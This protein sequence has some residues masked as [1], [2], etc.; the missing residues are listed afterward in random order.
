VMLGCDDGVGV[1]LKSQSILIEFSFVSWLRF[2]YLIYIIRH[3][4]IMF[5]FRNNKVPRI[6]SLFWNI[7]CDLIVRPH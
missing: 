6:V 1:S 5:V 4:F 2:I 3:F 7:K